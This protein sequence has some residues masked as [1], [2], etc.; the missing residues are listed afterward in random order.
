MAYDD[1]SNQGVVG[2]GS[3]SDAKLVNSSVFSRMNISGLSV[4]GFGSKYFL[5]GFVGRKDSFSS[6][7]LGR[8]ILGSYDGSSLNLSAPLPLGND[9]L[10][11]VSVAPLDSSHFVV[12]YGGDNG[13]N[14]RVGSL[15]V[16]PLFKS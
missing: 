12:A 1:N 6:V 2:V 15:H 7:N 10:N 5:I 9:N 14:V 8:V 13:G 11:S 3:F 16:T 4:A